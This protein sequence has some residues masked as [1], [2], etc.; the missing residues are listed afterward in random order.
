MHLWD[1]HFDFTP[2]APYDTMFD[3]DYE[4]RVTGRDFFYDAEINAA[5]VPRD[6]EHIIALYDGEI[7]WTDVVV[8]RIRRRPGGAEACS[9][10]RS[11]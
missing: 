10:T 11:S 6:K 3:P 4:G 5:M 1:V 2:P 7:R 9:R 8:G